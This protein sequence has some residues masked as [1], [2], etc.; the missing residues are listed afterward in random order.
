MHIDF[1]KFHD[2]KEIL[3]SPA[4]P[5]IRLGEVKNIFGTVNQELCGLMPCLRAANTGFRLAPE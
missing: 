5:W 2:K 3:F 4:P 1:L